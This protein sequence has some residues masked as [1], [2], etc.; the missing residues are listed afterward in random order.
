M[1]NINRSIWIITIVSY[2]LFGV[3]TFVPHAIST[4]NNADSFKSRPTYNTVTNS[5]F[6]ECNFI[7]SIDQIHFVNDINTSY[8]VGM[9]YLSFILTLLMLLADLL[10]RFIMIKGSQSSE[11]YLMKVVSD[12]LLFLNLLVT[13]TSFYASKIHYNNCIEIENKANWL[14]NDQL[15]LFCVVGMWIYIIFPFYACCRWKDWKKSDEKNKLDKFMILYLVAY[16]LYSI[17]FGFYCKFINF[18]GSQIAW[19][20]Y[21]FGNLGLVIIETALHFCGATFSMDI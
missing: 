13:P 19:E 17:I 5:K 15:Y 20:T 21:Q 1:E 14:L 18:I 4:F 12:I 8:T 11:R 7:P 16:G 10:R 3:G 9:F 2:S 6:A